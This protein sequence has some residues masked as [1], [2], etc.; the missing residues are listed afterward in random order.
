LYNSFQHI[1]HNKDLATKEI[2]EGEGELCGE[3]NTTQF[4]GGG[5]GGCRI[6]ERNVSTMGKTLHGIPAYSCLIPAD[7]NCNFVDKLLNEN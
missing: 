5:W 4:V 6:L 1:I 7:E 3:N 2:V